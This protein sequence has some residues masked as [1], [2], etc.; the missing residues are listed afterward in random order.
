MGIK[1]HFLSPL[2]SFRNLQSV[3]L[4]CG[5]RARTE[6]ITNTDHRFNAA[7]AGAQLLSQAADV[8]V[9]R[10][11]LAVIFQTPDLV[12]QLFAGRHA[13]LVSREDGEQ[14]E[15]LAGQLDAAPLAGDRKVGVIDL[16]LAVVVRPRRPLFVPRA[17]Q[18]GAHA[19]DEFAHAEGLR[20]VVVRSEERRVGKEWRC[21]WST[22]Y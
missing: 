9:E 3:G 22:S 11:G 18:R 8:D 15:F 19:G 2:P 17:S 1:F 14:R 13:P 6:T 16:E 20:D 7:A 21:G 12:E 4:V 10:A 5:F